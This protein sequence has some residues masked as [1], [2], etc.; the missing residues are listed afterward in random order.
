M[1]WAKRSGSKKASWWVDE[2]VELWE[3]GEAEV[4]GGTQAPWWVL[5]KAKQKDKGM[6]QEL[7]HPWVLVKDRKRA[8]LRVLVLGWMKGKG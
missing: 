8:F 4:W 1:Q 6:G 2:M 7:E 5:A 3:D